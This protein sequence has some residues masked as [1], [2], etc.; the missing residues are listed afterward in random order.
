M[1]LEG[2]IP[3]L[4]KSPFTANVPKSVAEYEERAPRNLPKGVLA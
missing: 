3:I 1:P 4:S 2:S